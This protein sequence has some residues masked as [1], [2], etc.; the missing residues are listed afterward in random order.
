MIDYFWPSENINISINEDKKSYYSEKNN[1]FINQ[2]LPKDFENK[3]THE[4]LDLIFEKDF[5]EIPGLFHFNINNRQNIKEEKNESFG[6]NIKN[7]YINKFIIKKGQK[8][9]DI[10]KE[11]KLG[12]LRKNSLK[13]GKHDKYQQDNVIR[14]FK[15]Q[16]LQNIYNY[17]NLSFKYNKDS[18]NRKPIN[19]IQKISSID[20]KSI[21]KFDNLIWINSKIKT[22]FSQKISS[23]FVNFESNYNSKLIQKIYEKNEEK[24]VIKILEKTIKEM[25]LIYINDDKDNEFPGF[26]TMKDDINKFKEMNEPEEYLQI[27]IS[28]CRN[29]INIF[30]RI[31]P[32]KKM[33]KKTKKNN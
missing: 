7:N 22:I 12:R 18:N 32:R 9:F 5:E 10:K 24:Q 6:N 20:T 28:I 25:W 33:L 13:K 17:I 19:I 23:K 4:N 15:A 8:I 21:S 16:F 11:I 27:Y 30:N 29:F 14:K 26:N 3:Y 31:K 1:S 2:N